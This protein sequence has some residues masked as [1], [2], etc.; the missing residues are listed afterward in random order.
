MK[1]L[2]GFLGARPEKDGVRFGVYAPDAS[3]VWVCLFDDKDAQTA[4]HALRRGKGGIWSAHI[5]GIGQGQRYGLRA[6]GPYDPVKGLRFDPLKVLVDPFASRIDRPF[7]FHHEL[8]A[9][10]G[11]HTD[12]AQR[13]PKAVVESLAETA[14]SPHRFNPG[15]L[16]Y[17][18][19]VRGFTMRHPDVPQDR[20]GS[21]AALSSPAVVEHLRKL[22]VD[23]VDL[24]PV[25]A[26]IDERHLGPLGLTN[27]WGYNPVTFCALDPRL[28]PNGF[29]DLTA[30][31]KAL[32]D[33][34]IATVLDLVFNH[35]GEGD[36]NGPVL[37]LRGLCNRQAYRHGAHGRLVNDTGTGNTVC[38]DHPFIVRLVLD[39]LRRFVTAGGVDGFRFDLA[40][41]LGRTRHGFRPDAPLLKA[42]LSDPVLTGRI[43]IAEPWD[44]GPG[45]YQLG[46]FPEPF[47]EW[48]D[49]YRDD[50]RRFWRGDIDTIG[51]LATRLAGSSDVFGANDAATTRTVNFIAAHDGF[52]LRD[53]VS[54]EAKHNMANGEENRDGH[55]EN[56]SW[57]N[58][59]EGETADKPIIAARQTDVR[60]LLATLFASRG[61]IMLTAGD[62][63]GRTQG[64]NNNAYAQDN[65]ISWLDWTGRDVALEEFVC[66]LARLRH[67]WPHLQQAG[68]FSGKPIDGSGGPDV[69]WRRPD[70]ILMTQ[71]DWADPQCGTLAMIIAHPLDGAGPRLAVLFNRTPQD[72]AFEL[73]QRPGFLW[74]PLV[75]GKASKSGAA[76]VAAR[77][78]RFWAERAG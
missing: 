2:Q 35:T 21:L 77:S 61:T 68:F 17:E 13:V 31:T 78:V 52:T 9:P 48:S 27:A 71:A 16:V 20:R 69:A 65:E 3:A 67:E 14:P 62:E 4:R 1:P 59:A 45:G 30:A 7:A 24:M 22:R 6:D 18:L 66:G 40:P 64:G 58:G 54:Y 51:T 26:W 47:L 38:C 32:R 55:N 15:C 23:A 76:D 19:N 42:I 49:R 37:S 56:L 75:N 5:T 8:E 46:R 43:L 53:L 73:P 25:A 36:E 44:V 11:T 63:F 74:R 72:R 29:A 70:G 33:A 60:A 12:T 10:R 28:A 34:G 57:N 39:S 41:V 50:V